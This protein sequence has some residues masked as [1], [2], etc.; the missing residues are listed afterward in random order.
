LENA[1]SNQVIEFPRDPQGALEVPSALAVDRDV[2]SCHGLMEQVRQ[3]RKIS[4]AQMA[5]LRGNFGRFL[6]GFWVADFCKGQIHGGRFQL[7]FMLQQTP[8]KGHP[9]KNRLLN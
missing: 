2:W 6:T 5:I 3:K 1:P 9:R 8:V 7:N 4:M